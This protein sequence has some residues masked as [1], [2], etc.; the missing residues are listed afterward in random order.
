MRHLRFRQLTQRYRL[1]FTAVSGL[2]LFP[3]HGM[4]LGM[5]VS[6][7]LTSTAATLIPAKANADQKPNIT[8]QPRVVLL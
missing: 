5:K 4:L 8:K 6:D 7:Y 1:P 3:V 2:R